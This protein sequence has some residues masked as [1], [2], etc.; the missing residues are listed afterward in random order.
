LSHDWEGAA[1]DWHEWL[2]Y[3]AAGLVALRIVCGFVGSRY[4]RFSEFVRGPRQLLDYTRAPFGGRERRYL[5]H[6]PLGALMVLLLMALSMGLAITGFVMT[7]RG[8][9]LFG[10]DRRPL[11]QLHDIMGNLYVVAVPVHIIAVISESI[12]HPRTSSVR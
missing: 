1:R 4:A 2:G 6:N 8:M 11:H 12:R 9:T 10:L 7:H 3:A 5:G